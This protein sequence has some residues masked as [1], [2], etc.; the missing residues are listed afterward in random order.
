MVS[1][2]SPSIRTGRPLRDL[3]DSLLSGHDQTIL[4][5]KR[6]RAMNLY[7]KSITDDNHHYVDSSAP[8]LIENY[9]PAQCYRAYMSR[10]IPPSL[11][12]YPQ[13]TSF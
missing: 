13:I 12:T 3:F 1:K 6:G 5:N 10:L 7:R 2:L 8:H 11:D 9:G 4:D